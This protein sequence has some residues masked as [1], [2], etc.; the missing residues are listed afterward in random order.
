MCRVA[1]TWQVQNMYYAM[2]YVYKS[3]MYMYVYT[4]VCM[5][6]R[7]IYCLVCMGIYI[8][9]YNIWLLCL[10]N[11]HPTLPAYLL[12]VTQHIDEIVYQQYADCTQINR[13]VAA[14]RRIPQTYIHTYIHTYI[15]INIHTSTFK[16]ISPVYPYVVVMCSCIY[17][18]SLA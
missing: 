18:P 4:Y 17:L 10:R 8:S 15:Q 5:Y 9:V 14:Q 3:A 11:I 16:I 2:P 1:L 13:Y 12:C 7:I 6:L